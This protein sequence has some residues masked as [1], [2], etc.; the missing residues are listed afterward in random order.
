LDVV[1]HLLDHA[2]R[3]EP[4]RKYSST[5]SHGRNSICITSEKLGPLVPSIKTANNKKCNVGYVTEEVVETMIIGEAPYNMTVD[6]NVNKGTNVDQ[7]TRQAVASR[8]SRFVIL[9]I[10]DYSALGFRLSASSYGRIVM[11]LFGNALKFT[12]AGYVHLSVRSENLTQNSGTVVLKIS[13]SGVG[14]NAQFLESAF[15]PFRKQN[16]HTAGTGVGL[17][18][19]KRILE[20]VGGRIDVFSEPSRGTQVILKLPLERLTDSE[21]SD[22][23]INPLPV[24]MA[25]IKGRKVCIL[26]SGD[27]PN[28]PP[29]QI[30]HK[31]T[32]KH[33]VDVLAATLENVCKLDVRFTNAWDGTDDTEVMICP[34][35][36]FDSLQM[37]RQNAAKAGRRCPATILIAM[38]IPEAEILRSDARILSRESIV[39]S[40]TQP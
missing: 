17:S 20:D 28:D 35:V 21:C 3:P 7:T 5:V 38:D 25:N 27:D 33:Y 14:M 6:S 1:E 2:E 23:K 31:W 8:R 34:E 24:A 39:E 16:E 10:S 15:E 18:V 36:S 9:D 26:Y 11:N 13:D 37:I 22:N 12:E 32:M 4:N 29:E 19:V 40:I 30:K